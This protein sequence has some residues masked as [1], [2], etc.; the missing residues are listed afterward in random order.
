MWAD[1]TEYRGHLAVKKTGMESY[2]RRSCSSNPV[3]FYPS[4]PSPGGQV[5]MEHRRQILT[6]YKVAF[7]LLLL[8]PGDISIYFADW[9][10]LQLT[11]TGWITPLSYCVTKTLFYVRL[12]TAS[13]SFNYSRHPLE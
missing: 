8:W 2:K 12:L 3:S 13:P 5:E 4:V 7:F 11:W 6:L 1:R 9:L 10:S